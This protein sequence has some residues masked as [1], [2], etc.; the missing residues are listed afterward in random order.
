MCL[1]QYANA[2]QPETNL[3][4]QA[5]RLQQEL[6]ERVSQLST[7]MA[8]ATSN[9]PELVPYLEK[10]QSLMFEYV[11]KPRRASAVDK[12]FANAL[13]HPSEDVLVEL[14]KQFKQLN[15]TADLIDQTIRA[16]LRAE[17]TQ[18]DSKMYFRMRVRSEIPPKTLKAY[19]MMGLAKEMRDRGKFKDALIFWDKSEVLINDSF[20]EHIEHMAQYREMLKNNVAKKRQRILNQVEELLKD[21]FVTIPAGEFTMGDDKGSPDEQPSHQVKIKSFKMGKTEVTFD[22]YDLCIE[23]NGCYA[24]PKDYGWGREGMPVIDVSHKD[25]NKRFLPWLNDLTGRNYRLPTEAEWE[26]AA[27][28]GSTEQYSW[29][30]AA[31]CSMARFD[32]GGASVCNTRLKKN[33]GTA[34]VASYSANNFGLYD[35]AGNVWEWVQDCWTSSYIGAPGDGKAKITDPCRVRVLRG[36]AWNYPKSGMRTANR[37][38][39]PNN[40]RRSSFG[41]R[42]VIDHE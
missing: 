3:Y 17:Q 18:R 13:S 25:I 20:N 4:Q 14:V 21:H 29:G 33:R 38:Y 31:T 11:G 37:F 7:H 15:E 8:N 19:G 23:A 34:A 5:E 16:E 24:V 30:D 41:F 26:Y 6:D 9:N 12:K 40:S 42:L 36:G 39:A 32:G 2:E 1:S 28:A 22:L 10:Q 27:R 35:M